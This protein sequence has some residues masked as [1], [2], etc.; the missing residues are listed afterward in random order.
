MI[1]AV[2]KTPELDHLDPYAEL[3]KSP[4]FNP[5]WDEKHEQ[6]L[7]T[8]YVRSQSKPHIPKSILRWIFLISR[9]FA[10]LLDDFLN[11]IR[12]FLPA[13][14]AGLT[15]ILVGGV[16]CVLH[17]SEVWDNI[18]LIYKTIKDKNIAQRKVKAAVGSISLLLGLSGTGISIPLVLSGFGLS[19]AGAALFPALIPGL[20][21]VIFGLKLGRFF[22]ALKE[23]RKDEVLAKAL[24][25]EVIRRNGGGIQDKML[26][27]A[28]DRYHFFYEQRRKAERKTAFTVLE[29]TCAA[30][31]TVGVALGT[32]ALLGTAAVASLGIAPTAIIL[33]AV[34]IAV[35]MKIF[36]FVDEKMHYS[37]THK[38]K[39][40]FTHDEAFKPTLKKDPAPSPKPSSLPKLRPKLIEE[41]EPLFQWKPISKLEE[42]LADKN[43]PPFLQILTQWDIL[44]FKKKKVEPRLQLFELVPMTP[45][46]KEEKSPALPKP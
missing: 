23:A 22:Y 10:D 25:Q 43:Q 20:L 24:L 6:K 40:W 19:I 13:A 4:L 29:M 33:T 14:L 3:H 1:V 18:K 11:A 16:G 12:N 31:V 46:E 26:K 21:T 41:K 17:L 30:L 9:K 27:E 36:E 28:Q 32:A 34:G 44:F 15:A 37:L 8:L 7:E 42:P 5:A 45:K 2:S 39:N 35:V 38:I